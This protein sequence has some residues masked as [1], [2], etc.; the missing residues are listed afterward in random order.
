MCISAIFTAISAMA[1]I[2]QGQQ[3]SDILI[4]TGVRT[5][6]TAKLFDRL[7]GLP[8]GL[9]YTWGKG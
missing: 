4:N 3:K 2:S 1:A 7:G 5:E 8:A 6:A 9:I